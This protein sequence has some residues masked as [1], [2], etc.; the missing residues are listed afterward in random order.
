MHNPSQQTPTSASLTESIIAALAL[1]R[2][3]KP[4]VVNITN[5]VVMN[6][7]A[8]ALLAIGA[9][10]IMAHSRQEM[11]EMMNIAGS[12]VINIGTL[13]S[14]WIDRMLFAVEQANTNN[15]PIVLDPVGCG[16]SVL[17]TQTARTLAA[18][19]NNLIIRGNA[20]EIIALAG[21]ASQTKGVDALDSSDTALAAAQALV[22]Q[23]HANV[24]ISGEVDY[25][26]TASQTIS[27]S[28]G[29]HMMPYVTGMGCSLTALT[30][31]FAAI[32]ETSG[33]AA[34]AI[35]A[36]AGEIAA[37]KS[38]GPA[39]LQLNIIDVLYHISAEQI[40]QRLNMDV[41]A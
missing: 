3:Q 11:A 20:S 23:Y 7:T 9:S 31:A 22:A 35:Y 16:A 8:N 39:S 27:L 13:D 4:L 5:Y 2:E 28:N 32:G 19:A 33:L 30:G 37:E 10:P 14:E 26:V 29:H 25:V 1:I 12:L 36:I 15:K 38:A 24:V 40:C 34:T 17:R 41:V 6:N 18:N 21:E